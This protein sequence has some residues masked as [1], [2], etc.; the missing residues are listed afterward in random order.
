MEP[1]AKPDITRQQ[2]A[3]GGVDGGPSKVPTAEL[4]NGSW[5]GVAGPNP[6]IDPVTETMRP[7]IQNSGA[8]S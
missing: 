4:P 3:K 7:M 2:Q 5:C 6:H 1:L 8:A